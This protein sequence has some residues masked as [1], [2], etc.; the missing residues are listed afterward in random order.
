MAVLKE[1]GCCVVDADCGEISGCTA[2]AEFKQYYYVIV[3]VS[4][5]V[6]SRANNYTVVCFISATRVPNVLCRS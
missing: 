2:Y 6:H 1:P 5:G 4:T 3:A